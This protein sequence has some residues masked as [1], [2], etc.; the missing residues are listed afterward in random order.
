MSSGRQVVLMDQPAKPIPP[1]NLTQAWRCAG[2]TTGALKT[3]TPIRPMGVVV[4]E[5]LPKSG[6][7]MAARW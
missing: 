6:F 5:V 1:M 4:L 7:E 3:K 2:G